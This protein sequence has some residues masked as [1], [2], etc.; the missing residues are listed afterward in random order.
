MS[1]VN[2]T[3]KLSFAASELTE[4]KDL[5]DLCLVGYSL[6]QRPYYE[7]L[8]TTM[9]KAWKLK[10][11]FSLLSLADDFFLLKFTYSEDFDMI[12]SGGPWFLL[13]KPFFLQKWNSKFQ[14]KRDE[15]AS[16][17]LWIKI[18]NLPLALWTPSGIS[19]IAS[20]IGIPLYVDSLTAKRTRLTFARVCVQVDKNS[21]LPDEIPLEIDGDDLVLKVVYD[22]KPS[23]C[24]GCGSIIHPY[25]L[26][27]SN[28]SP[29]PSL[30]PKPAF[31]GR[32][33]SRA[34]TARGKRSPSRPKVNFLVNPPLNI[35]SASTSQP[36]PTTLPPSQPAT[37]QPPTTEIANEP[38]ISPPDNTTS[39]PNLNLPH[40]ESSSSGQSHPLLLLRPSQ[41]VLA[42]S[43]ASLPVDNLDNSEEAKDDEV[44]S[45]SAFSEE[46][47]PPPL[48][49]K[50]LSP[51]PK[52]LLTL[53]PPLTKKPSQR[54]PKRPKNPTKIHN[55]VSHDPW[56]LFSHTLF[57]NEESYDN[58]SFSNPGRIWLKW[59][60]SQISFSPLFTS[61]QVVHGIV[62]A[63][64]LPPIYLSVVYAANELADRRL[65]WE[66]LLNL[67][68]GLE[69]PWVVMGDFNCCRFERE[70]AGGN[71]LP[72]D[73][74]G[75]LNT[76]V[77]YSGLQDLA[78]VGLFFTWHNQRT[79]N[80]IH[81]KLDR[82]LVNHAFL[83]LF[84][85]AFYKVDYP[86]G[87]D[88]SPLIL[89]ANPLKR[90]FSRFMYKAFWANMD[91]FWEE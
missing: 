54:R 12:W 29:K 3:K 36:L 88:H 68:V 22:W 17:P 11:S 46:V 16:I 72:A 70:K 85:S 53:F 83:D 64:S 7:R 60:A 2:P 57:H 44:Y 81:I 28:P 84:P 37:D 24:D 43:F 65:L 5:W 21:V 34:P 82:M 63:G 32:S 61:S 62:E 90:N 87:S 40:E 89:S 23:K 8:L 76:F 33:T 10:G 15:A 30:P 86:S 31:R 27:P 18:L 20:Y 78:S 41:V 45:S 50:L 38:L 9:N 75:E 66:D 79:D 35:N 91:G 80:P 77:F 55:S 4:G 51:T 13:G 69:H 39:L 71:P 56:F 26:C 6:G 73:R 49:P 74:L 48:P 25:A 14:P 58:F 67:S 59:D 42:N 1:F 52:L 47:L 19:K